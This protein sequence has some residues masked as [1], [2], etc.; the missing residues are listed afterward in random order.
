MSAILIG[1]FIYF[2]VFLIAAYFISDRATSGVNDDKLRSEYRKYYK[3]L[4]ILY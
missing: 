3:I 2:V 4:L 1:S